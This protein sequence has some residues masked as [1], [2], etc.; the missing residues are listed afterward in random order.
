MNKLLSCSLSIAVCASLLLSPRAVMAQSLAPDEVEI[1]PL[2]GWDEVPPA[3]PETPLL[4][5]I[6]SWLPNRIADAWD[7]FRVDAG[8]GP[9]YGGTIRMTRHLQASYREFEPGSLRVGAMGRRAPIMW[10]HSDESG[11]APVDFSPS[12]QRDVCTYEIGV[13]VELLAGGAYMGFC[14]E[15]VVDFV[16]GIFFLDTED[17]DAFEELF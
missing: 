3:Q 2:Q 5:S 11:V 7:I 8:V 16:A 17:D 6:I 9:A 12:T 13:G 14:P 15:E 1:S 10:E 4:I